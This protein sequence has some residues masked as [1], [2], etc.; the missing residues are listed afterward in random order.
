MAVSWNP[1]QY[2]RFADDRSR[3]FFDL[4]ARVRIQQPRRIV[5]LGC[6]AG[7][8]TAT[9]AQRWPAAKVLGIDSSSDMLAEALAAG[10]RGDRPTF[11]WGNIAT[12][13]A[14]PGLD[15]VVSNAAL[16]W[17]PGH[18]TLLA[19][20]A[21]DLP[22]GAEM[23]W[24]VPGNFDAPSHLLLRELAESAR[25]SR[26]LTGV[27][28]LAQPV[29]TPHRYAELL[30]R[31]GWSADVWETTY[32]HVLS[33][34]N[35]VLEWVRGT[36]LRPVLSALDPVDGRRFEQEYASL[37]RSAYPTT[38]SGTVFPFRRIFAVGRKGEAG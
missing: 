12:W 3:P 6:G 32:L 28:R 15:L 14:D 23:A 16:Q 35:A 33:G 38:S 2:S 5:D 26:Q 17:V 20:W 21:A 1:E 19:G 10:Q 31:A 29:A 36:A 30:L 8:L 11:E 9:L 18:L 22:V 27:L 4:L 7:A 37:L 34:E 25:W 13:R 24:Q